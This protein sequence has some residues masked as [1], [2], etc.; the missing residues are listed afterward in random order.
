MNQKA[1][2][3]CKTSAIFV[4]ALTIFV[5]TI[6]VVAVGLVQGKEGLLDMAELILLTVFRAGI[7]TATCFTVYLGYLYYSKKPGNAEKYDALVK[8]SGIGKIEKAWAKISALCKKR[9]D[10]MV[11]MVTAIKTNRQDTE[12][13]ATVKKLAHGFGTVK[14]GVDQQINDPNVV[15]GN[16]VVKRMT[17]FGFSHK[18]D[19][20]AF[21]EK[22]LCTTFSFGPDNQPESY[23]AEGTLTS[24]LE[25]NTNTAPETTTHLK[26]M[27]AVM[28]DG[29]E[30]LATQATAIPTTPKWPEHA[31]DGNANTGEDIGSKI[32][33]AVVFEELPTPQ[34]Q[35]TETWL[36]NVLT[37]EYFNRTEQ[38][39]NH[40]QNVQER[41]SALLEGRNALIAEAKRL[42]SQ[43]AINA[44]QF[45]KMTNTP[46]TA[47][48]IPARPQSLK[49]QREP[50][51][52][53]AG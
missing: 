21:T 47:H 11:E 16:D 43:G 6:T 33:A 44:R 10:S 25:A 15:S 35:E 13:K 8:A 27:E 9:K 52:A 49:L 5:M 12:S 34:P 31:T 2:L 18:D 19:D 42:L 30:A 14:T 22:I 3:I 53:I 50:A 36:D 23:L 45:V 7:F 26:E 4:A 39:L 29:R 37:P 32:P 28:K 48:Q 1:K 38:L 24:V 51:T 17:E 20:P 40:E 46:G 41:F